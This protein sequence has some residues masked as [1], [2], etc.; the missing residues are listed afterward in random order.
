[1]EV[2]KL[3]FLEN[4]SQFRC[5]KRRKD[6]VF[7]LLC[8]LRKD[9]LLLL[10]FGVPSACSFLSS[11]RQDTQTVLVCFKTLF[12]VL[13]DDVNTANESKWEHLWY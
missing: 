3:M 11:E 13:C 6:T 10:L 2:T 12:A 8:I 9:R 1:M 5:C 4:S 7:T